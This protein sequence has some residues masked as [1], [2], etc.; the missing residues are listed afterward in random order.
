MKTSYPV[1]YDRLR[2]FSITSI[3]HYLR[4]N[5]NHKGVLY[6]TN[7]GEIV[8]NISYTIDMEDLFIQL[9]YQ[10]KKQEYSYRI[11]IVSVPSNIGKAKVW[12]FICPATGIRCRKLHFYNNYFVHRNAINGLYDQQTESKKMRTFGNLCR[13][14]HRSDD[15]RKLTQKKGYTPFYKG[16]PTKA[17]KKICKVNR[18]AAKY[19]KDDVSRIIKDCL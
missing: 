4:N 17:F 8:M 12:Y 9:D 3:N 15:I 1:L 2:V 19:N 16:K 10:S 18:Q 5:L 6:W 11:K 14:I 7:K 13:A